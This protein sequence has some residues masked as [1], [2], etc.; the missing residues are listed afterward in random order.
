MNKQWHG[1]KGSKPRGGN[2]EQY[3]LLCFVKHTKIMYET[4][5]TNNMKDYTINCNY[6][7]KSFNNGDNK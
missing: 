4:W 6:Y 3:N 5:K 7:N 2:D 1:G